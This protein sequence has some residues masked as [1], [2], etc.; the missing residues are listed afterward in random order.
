[1][2]IPIDVLLRKYQIKP[3]AVLHV[4]ANE[5]QEARAYMNAGIPN[6]LFIEALPEVYT[7]LSHNLV[8]TPYT[9]AKACIT[10]RDYDTVTFNVANNGGQSSSVLQ[11]GQ[12]HLSAHPEV[13]MTRAISMK[14]IRLDTLLS[15]T[16]M[17]FDFINFDLQGAELLA[18]HSLGAR[19]KDVQVAYLEIN[20]RETYKGCA[21]IDEVTAFMNKHGLYMVEQSAWIGDT[22]ADSFWLLDKRKK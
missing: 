6:G 22:W 18:L 1:M 16:D 11:F 3:K 5:G 14:T 9:A 2:L 12:P 15:N 19:M 17:K 21:L 8:Q 10:D 4:G 13:K 20:K 7:K